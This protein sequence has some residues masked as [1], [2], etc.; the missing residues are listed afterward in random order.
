MKVLLIRHGEPR[1]DNVKK[2]NLVAYLGELTKL[3][4][5]QAEKVSRD[6]RLQGAEI[7]VSS[8]F[9]RALQTAAIISKN[10]GIPLTVETAFHEWLED[11]TH[12][13][14]LDEDYCNLAD[15]EFLENDF[16]RV[17]TNSTRYESIEQLANRAYPAMQEYVEA[18]YKKIIVVAHAMFMRTMGYKEQALP[19]CH[20]FER[21]FDENSKFEG[22]IPWRNEK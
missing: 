11:T 17:E 22:F 8:P 2:H 10:T 14:T 19:N 18:G 3:G 4:V 15:K 5:E 13:K 21:E 6:K 1:Y 20:I 16:K 12:L 9:T 7:I